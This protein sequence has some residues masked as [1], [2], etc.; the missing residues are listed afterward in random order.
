VEALAWLAIPTGRPAAGPRWTP[1][2]APVVGIILLS[3]VHLVR[4]LLFGV[5]AAASGLSGGLALTVGWPRR[6]PT[7]AWST[8]GHA[9][10]VRSPGLAR[11]VGQLA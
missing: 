7:R 6:A 3:P 11:A 2:V 10:S 8:S 4:K 1:E 9:V 5:I